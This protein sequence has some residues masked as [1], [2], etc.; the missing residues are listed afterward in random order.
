MQSKKAGHKNGWA[1]AAIIISSVL[2]VVGIIVGIIVVVSLGAAG[3]GV[4]HG[5]ARSYGTG[6]HEI[7]NGA[8]IVC[9]ES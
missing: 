7:S 3:R 1:V 2:I 4:R 9:P 6:T 8:N 5:C